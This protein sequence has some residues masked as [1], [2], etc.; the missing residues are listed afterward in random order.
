MF[1][2]FPASSTAQGS[3]CLT[4]SLTNMLSVTLLSLSSA[5]VTV[6]QRNYLAINCYILDPFPGQCFRRKVSKTRLCLS[7]LTLGL[8]S[9]IGV[10]HEGLFDCVYVFYL[11]CCMYSHSFCVWLSVTRGRFKEW[12]LGQWLTRPSRN[13]KRRPF[14]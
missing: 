5:A 2:V 12:P 8:L 1:V 6:S 4:C 14:G 13:E 10:V 3:S 7:C 9:V 11:S